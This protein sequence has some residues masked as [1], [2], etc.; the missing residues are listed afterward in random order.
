MVGMA[1][2]DNG[3]ED[4]AGESVGEMSRDKSLLAVEGMKG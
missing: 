3:C 2:E 4:N 1:C